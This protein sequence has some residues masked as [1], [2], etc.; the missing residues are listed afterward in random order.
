MVVKKT[1]EIERS[2]HQ[3]RSILY[4]LPNPLREY[5]TKVLGPN[6]IPP[7]PP[8]TLPPTLMPPARTAEVAAVCTVDED[9]R[10]DV[11]AC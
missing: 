8:P 2:S 9:D 1:I 4:I 6:T 3:S 7:P 11:G 5:T 10:D